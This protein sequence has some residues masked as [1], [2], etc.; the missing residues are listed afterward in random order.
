MNIQSPKIIPRDET[1]ISKSRKS[2]F[3]L[4]ELLVVIGIIALLISILLPALSKARNSANQL[5]C[6]SN[7]KQIGLAMRMY[8]DN[9]RGRFPFGASRTNA[10]TED[11]LWWQ[12]QTVPSSTAV[13][14]PAPGRPVVDLQGSA[15]AY[16]LGGTV[17]DKYL[18]CPTDSVDGRPA[19]TQGG[20]YKYSYTMNTQMCGN[21]TNKPQIST[22]RRISTKILMIEENLT[23]IN[24]G[25]WVGPVYDTTTGPPTV[26]NYLASNVIADGLKI[27]SGTLDLLSIAHDHS[28]TQ[29]EKT[30][31][32]AA[33]EDMPNPDRKGPVVFVDG[34]AESVTRTFAHD[35]RHV[36]PR[37]D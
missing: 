25:F 11:W 18:R 31:F 21:F 27:S 3:T 1:T 5:K 33:A 20:I 37:A 30:G 17:S 28:N 8:A 4:V 29:P 9:N 7:L 24:D 34:H 12:T 36:D 13:T 2:G 19:A 23:T 14:P 15:L 10:Y 35:F 16:Y 22:M 26:A 6:L 32:N